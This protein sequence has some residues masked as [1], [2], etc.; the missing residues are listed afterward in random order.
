MRSDHIHPLVAS[1]LLGDWDDLLQPVLVPID[2][3]RLRPL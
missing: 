2:R 1:E 3:T